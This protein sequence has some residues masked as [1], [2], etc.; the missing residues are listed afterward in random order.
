MRGTTSIES[1]APAIADQAMPTFEN[2]CKHVDRYGLDNAQ[3]KRYTPASTYKKFAKDSAVEV[4]F[5]SLSEDA[6]VRF[7]VR[8]GEAAW[9]DAARKDYQAERGGS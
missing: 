2:L 7:V 4:A 6:Y 5:A 1:I 9:T 8:Y 3:A